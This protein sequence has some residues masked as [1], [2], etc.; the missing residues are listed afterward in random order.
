MAKAKKKTPKAVKAPQA[1]TIKDVDPLNP[2]QERA[3]DEFDDGKNLLLC[4]SAGTGK[5]FIGLYLALSDVIER[6]DPLIYRV[7]IVRS[8]VP[9]RDIGFLK[10]SME[11]K[12]AAYEEPYAHI[13][14]SLFQCGT[15]YETLKQKRVVE[16]VTTSYCRGMTIDNAII[17]VDE[18]QNMTDHELCTIITRMGQNSRIIICGDS[19]Q[20][21]LN[22]KKEE[23]GFYNL[24]RVVL[25]MSDFFARIEFTPD[26]IVRHGLV[27]AF[28]KTRISLGLD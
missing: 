3:I 17:V 10:G 19:R 12:A 4:G 16:F 24:N 27:K 7:V 25:N 13:I 18:C 5:S 20:I 8:A 9:T 23:S 2:R 6:V 21:D 14:N 26:D 1:L 11:E 15:A 22:Q 28:L